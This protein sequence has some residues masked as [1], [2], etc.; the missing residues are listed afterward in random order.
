MDE[1]LE[2]TN[3]DIEPNTDGCEEHIKAG[4]MDW[5]ALN[6]CLTCGHV[7]CCDSTPEQHAIEHFRK[8]GHAIV[9]RLP[10]PGTW[11]WCYIH[12]TYVD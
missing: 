9:L 3:P 6:L 2:G 5:V 11:K 4:N 8:T 7:G 12:K 1:H 10:K